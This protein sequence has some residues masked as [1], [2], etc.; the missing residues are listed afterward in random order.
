MI[1]LFGRHRDITSDAHNYWKAFGRTSSEIERNTAPVHNRL[2]V[3]LNRAHLERMTC[4][5]LGIDFKKVIEG[6]YILL[7]DLGGSTIKRAV[8]QLGVI[9]FAQLYYSALNLEAGTGEPRHFLLVDEAH[10]FLRVPIDKM[11]EEARKYQLSLLLADQSLGQIQSKVIRDAITTNKGTTFSF[12]SNNLNE[13]RGD[14]VFFAPHYVPEDILNQSVGEA[15]LRSSVKGELMA[16]VQLKVT[17]PRN[18]ASAVSI[19]EIKAR[20]RDNLA[21]VLISPDPA[22]LPPRLMTKDEIAD[23]LEQ[24]HSG[25]WY[26]ETL[27]PE[28]DTVDFETRAE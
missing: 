9:L 5:P 12:G 24:R 22:K 20:S 16:P 18:N 13:A 6:N 14:A 19:E 1:K 26:H 3:F 21:K 7:A 8:D 25:K 28:A 2:N 4:H 10:S 15:I 23:W 17:P 11:Y 27:D